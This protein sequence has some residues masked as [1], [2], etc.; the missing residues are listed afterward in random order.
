[1]GTGVERTCVAVAGPRLE[2]CGTNGTGADP[3]APH[4]RGYTE[5]AGHR[6]A[7]NR[8][9]RAVGSRPWGP[10]FVHR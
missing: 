9:G 2:E 4:S 7:E 8:A 1:M 6:V 5:R 3:E 10:T